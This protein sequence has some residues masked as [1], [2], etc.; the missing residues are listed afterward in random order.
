MAACG[1]D[2]P[3]NAVR[4]SGHVEATAVR[5]APRVGG[6]IVEM[7]VAEGD[8]VA[9]DAVV[10]RLDTVDTELAL[11]RARADQDQASAQLRLLQAGPRAEDVRVAE[12]QVVAARADVTTAAAER[13]AAE[14]DAK[15]FAQLLASNSGTRKQLDDANARLEVA[16]GREAAARERVATAEQALARAKAGARPE[17]IEAARAR[18]AAAAAQV[19]VFD[20]ALADAVV[21]T[22]VGGIVTERLADPG[23]T[24]QPRAPLV[25]VTDLDRAWAD[26]YVDEPMV[27][28]LRLSQEV[29]LHTD[30][31]G[32]GIPAT[33]SFISPTAEFTP[34]NVQTADDR[35]RLVYR[36]KVSVDNRDGVLKVGMPV[37][38]EIPLAPVE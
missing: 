16:A 7:S 26:V 38:A 34:R 28:R 5:V 3:A 4:V 33:I 17:E 37:E 20:Q 2:A 15:R 11:A 24:V 22:P 30:A 1:P 21:T 8:R 13:A 29:T 14:I 19:A 10:A 32:P 9:P 18:V 25:V 23:E 36:V 31:G 6:R 27:P 12:S 35:A